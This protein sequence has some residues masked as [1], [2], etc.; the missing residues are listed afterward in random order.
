MSGMTTESNTNAQRN[1]MG[2]DTPRMG[3]GQG[4]ASDARMQAVSVL[5]LI[6][7]VVLAYMNSLSGSFIFDDWLCIAQNIHIRKLWPLT[8]VLFKAVA[9]SPTAGRPIVS[10]TLAINYTFGGLDVRGYHLFNMAVH[11]ASV[12]VLWGL[13]GRTFKNTR[14]NAR[15][16]RSAPSLALAIA[17]VW[18][19]HPIH[20][21]SLN[22]VSQRTELLMGLFYL[23]TLYCATRSWGTSRRRSWSVL[24]VVSCAFGMGCKEVMVSAPL[25]VFLYD[26]VL[27]SASLRDALRR[28]WGLHIGLAATWGVLAWLNLHGPRMQSAG[29]DLGI[30]PLDYLRTQAAIIVWYLR[31]SFWPDRLVVSY[32]DWPLAQ[33]FQAIWPQGLFIVAMLVLT[34]WALWRRHPA[35]L[36]GAWFFMILAPSSSFVPIVTEIAAERRMYLPLAAV[37]IA[38]VLVIDALIRWAKRRPVGFLMGNFSYTAVVCVLIAVALGVTTFLRNRVYAS[39]IGIWADTVAKRPNNPRALCNLGL[40]LMSAGQNEQ[41]VRAI[42][43]AIEIKNDDY[44]MYE[45]RGVALV[46]LGQLIQAIQD[47]CRAIELRPDYARAYYNRG[48]A[49]AQMSDYI[50][51]IEDWSRAIEL[52]PTLID[53]YICRGLAS[54]LM[55]NHEPALDDFSTAIELQPDNARAYGGRA[56]AYFMT[57]AYDKA[58]ADLARCQELGGQVNPGFI[59]A[60]NRVS[61]RPRST[62]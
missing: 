1:A 60:L 18:A 37:V 46:A 33:S 35:S 30:A 62:E 39:E 36:L 16:G 55:Q 11:L 40:A 8:D 57:G 17:L 24:A 26:V 42:T 54:N 9:D 51:A 3:A 48:I 31:L 2:S 29:F 13:L 52:Q 32:D 34:A 6:V 10:L 28:H 58:R 44:K 12:L 53:A 15:F 7:A 25:M 27:V 21:E 20:T 59:E 14:L 43:K 23:L 50:K 56:N 5:V 49:Y 22:Y 4:L 45:S 38:V 41:A 19:V 47:Y 61:L